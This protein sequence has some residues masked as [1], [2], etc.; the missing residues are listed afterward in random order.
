MSTGTWIVKV[1]KN[2]PQPIATT[3]SDLNFVGAEYEPI[4]LVATQIVNGTNYAVLAKQTIV[5]GKD[6]N[7]IVL[8]EHDAYSWETPEEIMNN[9]LLSSSA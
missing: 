5:T 8:T 1:E 9:S 2:F 4:A 3:I 7:N 6:T